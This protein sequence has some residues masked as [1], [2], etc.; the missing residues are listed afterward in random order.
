[1]NKRNKTDGRK[2]TDLSSLLSSAAAKKSRYAVVSSQYICLLF[3]C[4]KQNVV[5]NIEII[6]T[7]PAMVLRQFRL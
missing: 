2:G 3:L 5:T 7:L 1:M 6:F 4:M